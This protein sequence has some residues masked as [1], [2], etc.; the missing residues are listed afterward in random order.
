MKLCELTGCSPKFYT[1]TAKSL[2]KDL[3]KKF[4]CLYKTSAIMPRNKQS[5][6][7][8]RRDGAIT[9]WQSQAL[10][11]WRKRWSGEVYRVINMDR[12]NTNRNWEVRP[13]LKYFF[14]NDDKLSEKLYYYTDTWLWGKNWY[15]EINEMQQ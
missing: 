3:W 8:N 4:L 11:F 9:I 13:T 12:I 1:A 2:R 10:R 15:I 7:R 14:L 5:D 6:R